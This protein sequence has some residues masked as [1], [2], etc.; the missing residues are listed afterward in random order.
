MK[1]WSFYLRIL[2]L[3]LRQVFKIYLN[4]FTLHPYCCHPPLTWD[5][6]W[7][8]SKPLSLLI[9]SYSLQSLLPWVSFSLHVLI[10]AKVLTVATVLYHLALT[11]LMPLPLPV[12]GLPL[13]GTVLPRHTKLFFRLGLCASHTLPR[14]I[15][16]P[17]LY[18]GQCFP[19]VSL[20]IL[21]SEH[22]LLIALR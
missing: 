19:Q 4:A 21:P 14:N 13:L 17:S 5:G 9:I 1:P 8:T 3:H 11:Q 6:G 18:P 15:C 12:T 10:T 7:T 2:P 16:L 22:P 20:L